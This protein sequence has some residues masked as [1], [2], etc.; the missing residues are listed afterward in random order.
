MISVIEA[1]LDDPRPVLSQQEFKA[2]GE[3]VAAMKREG[4]EYDQRMELLEQITYPKPLG[5]LLEQSF[6][7]FASSQP[8][9]RDFE[10]RPK[11]VVRDMFERAMSFAEFVELL[12]SSPAARA[13]CCATSA[14]PTAR[15]ARPCRTT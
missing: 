9:I 14:T 5:E 15:S 13:S 2:R 12:L 11:S 8:W 1:T 10:L 3:A 6:E 4:I 7:V